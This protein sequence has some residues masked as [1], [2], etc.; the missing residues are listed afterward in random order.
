MKPL[1]LLARENY[2][3]C[4]HIPSIEFEE[5]KNI[6]II[7]MILSKKP[8]LATMLN[9]Y[10]KTPL[11]MAKEINDVKLREEIIDCFKGL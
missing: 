7:K 2:F 11:D 9:I 5:I 10:N 3:F 1:V 4:E 6:E 8:E